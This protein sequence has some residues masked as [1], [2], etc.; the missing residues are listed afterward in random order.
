MNETEV[1]TEQMTETVSE[2]LTEADTELITESEMKSIEE[3]YTEITVVPEQETESEFA[4]ETG[5]E[6][7]I[8]TELE[9]ELE[10]ELHTSTEAVGIQFG[11]G[12]TVSENVMITGIAAVAGIVVMILIFCI[13]KDRK[14]SRK[15][16]GHVSPRVGDTIEIFPVVPPEEKKEDKPMK[17]APAADVPSPVAPVYNKDTVQ[18]NSVVGRTV[19]E[20]V[21]QDVLYVGKVHGVGKRENQQD[22]FGLSQD[23][24]YVETYGKGL[25]AVVADGMGGLANGAEMSATVTLTMLETFESLPKDMDSAER[26]RH[27]LNRANEEVNLVLQRNGGQ[28]SGSTLISVLITGEKMH[29]ISVGDSHIYLYRDNQLRQLNEDHVYGAE[30]DELVAQGKMSRSAALADPQR[31]ALTSYVGMGTIEKID[32]GSVEL[33]Q[34]DCIMLMSDGVF[35]TLSDA[36]MIMAAKQPPAAGAEQIDRMVKEKNK[37]FQDNYTALILSWR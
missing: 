7:E 25:L 37:R 13:L 1:L 26:L 34:G 23:G 24:P 11:N 5:F 35:G 32:E 27:M 22:A 3:L 18:K 10:T 31:A 16:K 4:E 30:L 14:N 2:M 9:T 19:E 36:E 28:R 8:G 6:T 15:T 33:R 21:Q 29:W 12:I 17:E 20:M